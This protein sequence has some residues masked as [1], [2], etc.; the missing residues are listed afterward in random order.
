MLGHMFYIQVQGYEK[1]RKR[2]LEEMGNYINI[3]IKTINNKEATRELIDRQKDI[4]VDLEK[5]DLFIRSRDYSILKDLEEITKEYSCIIETIQTFSTERYIYTHFIDYISGV[6]ILVDLKM[7]YY[8]TCINVNTLNNYTRD[9]V[10]EIREMMIEELSKN[11]TIEKTPE[12]YK[13]NNNSDKIFTYEYQ[14]DEYKFIGTK[15]G[16]DIDLKVYEWKEVKQSYTDD[17]D[18]I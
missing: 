9:D 5:G 3:T 7:T 14:E 13:V 4:E 8:V 16:N 11:D 17:G 12:G 10:I 6:G 2:G 18:F 1:N 15:K